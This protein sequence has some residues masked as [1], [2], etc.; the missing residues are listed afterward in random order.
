MNIRVGQKVLTKSGKY[1]GRVVN[2]DWDDISD[3]VQKLY[4]EKRVLRFFAVKKYV[5]ARSQIVRILKSK[6][7]VEDAVLHEK[8]KILLEVDSFAM[9]GSASTNYQP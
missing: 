4:V 9:R 5:I 8:S 6:I 2:F 3:S 7:I 1:L